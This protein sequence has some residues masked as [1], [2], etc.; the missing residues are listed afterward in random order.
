[1]PGAHRLS[2]ASRQLGRVV[3]HHFS[4][5]RQCCSHGVQI[6]RLPQAGLLIF[7]CSPKI[8]IQWASIQGPPPAG[9]RIAPRPQHQPAQRLAGLQRGGRVGGGAAEQAQLLQLL[10][11][12]VRKGSKG[13]GE[14]AGEVDAARTSRTAAPQPERLKCPW[15]CHHPSGRVP[16]VI[17]YSGAASAEPNSKTATACTRPPH[18]WQARDAVVAEVQ[19]G[20]AWEGGHLVG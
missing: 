14:P 3:S 18:V 8:A 5:P 19:G 16:L 1:M 6:G 4:H 10:Q 13:W 11:L 17:A 15:M 12:A 9:H 20:Q 2:G 7:I